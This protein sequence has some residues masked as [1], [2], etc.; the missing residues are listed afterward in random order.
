MYCTV[1]SRYGFN[2]GRVCTVLYIH[3]MDLMQAEYV[4]YGFNAQ[5][6]TN[7]ESIQIGLFTPILWLHTE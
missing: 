4:L 2:T 1:Y 7:S 5:G 6:I 3:D